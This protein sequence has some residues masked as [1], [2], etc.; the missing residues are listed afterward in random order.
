MKTSFKVSLV[1][2]LLSIFASTSIFA[3][4]VSTD[5]APDA[6]Q[7][8]ADRIL[9]IVDTVLQQHIDPPTRQQMLLDGAKAVYT[10]FEETGM[11]T[12]KQPTLRQLSEQVSALATRKQHADFVSELR[13]K[14]KEK[15]PTFDNH[16]ID[17]M[18]RA[19]PGGGHLLPAQEARV[20]NQLAANRYVGIGI[21][22]GMNEEGPRVQRVLHH[23]PGRLAG[24]K[25]ADQI[26][27]ID[28]EPTKGKPM[29][30]ILAAL[31]GEEGSVVTLL[32][33]HGGQSPRTVPV[34]RGKTFMPT[35]VGRK[36]ISEAEW[37]YILPDNP[38]I[39]FVVVDRIGPSTAHELK[40]IEASLRG[41]EITGLILDLR[42]GGGI[43][44]DV[45][46]LADQ[47]L[48]EGTIGHV[49][50]ANPATYDARPG[51]IFRDIPVAVLLADHSNADRVYL[52][53]AL[54][55]NKRAFVVGQPNHQA[56]FV[57]QHV[58]LP[59]GEKLLLATGK[60]QRGDGTTLTAFNRTRLDGY[61]ELRAMAG[62]QV[63]EKPNRM[64]KTPSYVWPDYQVRHPLPGERAAR[65]DDVFLAKA[66]E[67][68][69]KHKGV[70]RSASSVRQQGRVVLRE[71]A[72]NSWR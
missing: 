31:R 9:A 64:K 17:G 16:F 14:L 52:A 53:A 23:G 32:L 29:K 30:E 70:R 55:D 6:P 41:S 19:L 10:H 3:D 13:T 42:N 22:L 49:V 8:P 51:S 61:A 26:L 12:T 50:G 60:L 72:A 2:A 58:D 27:E 18:F 48:D 5:I 65:T 28:G 47:F 25:S 21:G 7:A 24:L 62:A 33:K 15:L 69:S 59:S 68:L 71:A 35:L 40:K 54:Q 66:V 43:L 36:K 20:Q 11:R 57:R 1:V 4:S 39:A 44:H 63:L 37:D 67:V 56:V 34:T 38:S 45:V 46:L